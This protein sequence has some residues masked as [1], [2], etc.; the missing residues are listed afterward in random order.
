MSRGPLHKA[1]ISG[2]C[3]TVKMLLESGEN[4]DQ[5]DKVLVFLSLCTFAK[6]VARLLA[7]A[8]LGD[9][10]FLF[11]VSRKWTRERHIAHD[12]VNGFY[13]KVLI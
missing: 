2:Q 11:Y 4:V 6:P 12:V 10:C 8:W 13:P 3:E 9:S 1:A 7:F 5:R